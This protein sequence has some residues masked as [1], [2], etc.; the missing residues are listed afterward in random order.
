MVV[1]YSAWSLVMSVCFY[2][3]TYLL[4]FIFVFIWGLIFFSKKTKKKS[5]G[6][7][8]GVL[9]L[10]RGAILYYLQWLYVTKV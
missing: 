2:I 6:G 1:L 3:F 4:V 9:E 8:V 7:R 10:G 5:R